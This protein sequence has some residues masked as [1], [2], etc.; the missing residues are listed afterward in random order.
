MNKTIKVLMVDDEEKFRAT[1]KKIL[2]RRGFETILAASGHEA[3]DK[4]EEK[5]DVVVLDIKMPDMDGHQVLAEMKKRSPALPVIMLTGHG[6]LPSAK[7]ALDVGAFD[8]LLKPCD[9]DLLTSKIKDA[10]RQ[11]TAEGMPREKL[12]GEIMIPIDEYTVLHEENTVSEAMIRLKESIAPK[13]STSLIVEKMHRSLLVFDD[14]ERVK[15]LLTITDLL[16]AIM[17]V[18]LSAPKPSMADSMVYS[19]IFWKGMFTQQVGDL[20][21]KKVKDIMSPAPL[22]ISANANLMEA[23]HSM[24][25]NSVRRLTVTRGGE[26]VGVVRELDLFFEIDAIN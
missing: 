14:R 17:P 16:Q 8:Y 25:K 9:I 7:E 2:D 10:C 22:S 5:P 13:I 18:Y 24:I 11:D 15:G 6:A 20:V 19:A 23:A 4:L 21:K 26:V 3:L 1:T 12:V